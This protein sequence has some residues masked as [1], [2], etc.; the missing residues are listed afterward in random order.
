MATR[1]TTSVFASFPVDS[2]CATVSLDMEANLRE[3]DSV[4]L[5]SLDGNYSKLRIHG[6]TTLLSA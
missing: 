4:V 6:Q 3:E 5:L 2:L 1:K